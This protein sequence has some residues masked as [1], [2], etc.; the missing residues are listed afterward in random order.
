MI[1]ANLSAGWKGL[2]RILLWIPYM[3]MI[4]FNAKGGLGIH[5]T[6]NNREMKEAWLDL[7]A[8]TPRSWGNNVSPFSYSIHGNS[9]G[10]D[11]A[12]VKLYLN[13]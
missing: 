5:G 11:H 2:A 13:I 8:Y 7:I 9:L 10:S 4:H 12:H 1:V 3:C 6:I